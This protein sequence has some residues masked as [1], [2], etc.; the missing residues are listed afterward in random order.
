MDLAYY[1]RG[2]V[3]FLLITRCNLSKKVHRCGQQITDRSGTIVSPK[4]VRDCVRNRKCDWHFVFPSG[5]NALKWNFTSTTFQT[6]KDLL[7]ASKISGATIRHINFDSS[8]DS[9]CYVVR[10]SKREGD[11]S[12]VSGCKIYT[13][14]VTE[15]Y[16]NYT[17]DPSALQFKVHY[18][19]IKYAKE[20]TTHT[21]SSLTTTAATYSSSF[22]AHTVSS[23][24]Q[25]SVQS[26]SESSSTVIDKQNAKQSSTTDLLS[27]NNI[28]HASKSLIISTPIDDKEVMESE[29]RTYGHTSRTKLRK[30]SS[31]RLKTEYGETNHTEIDTKILTQYLYYIVIPPSV[32]IAAFLAVAG[33][34]A[35]CIWKKRKSVNLQNTE[36]ATTSPTT[37]PFASMMPSAMAIPNVYEEIGVVAPFA[38]SALENVDRSSNTQNCNVTFEEGEQSVY[39]EMNSIVRN[40]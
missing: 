26:T 12:R 21:K 7:F 34:L 1:I 40:L 24:R 3:F 16:I 22:D 14:N 18:E 5:F 38:N 23:N 30:T 13:E 11:S 25:I 6:K 19:F 28:K 31:Y 4:N 36:V 29:A 9:I 10:T 15:P 8:N 39:V 17:C 37:T 33:I 27:T 35:I 32:V 2:F 20:T